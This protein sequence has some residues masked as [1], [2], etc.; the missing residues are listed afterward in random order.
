MSCDS[1]ENSEIKGRRGETRKQTKRR[2][3]RGILMTC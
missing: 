1:K 3:E 2:N